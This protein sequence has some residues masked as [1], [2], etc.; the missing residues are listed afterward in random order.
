MNRLDATIYNESL[1]ENRLQHG[2]IVLTAGGAPSFAGK[3][4]SLE[5]GFLMMSRCHEG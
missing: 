3:K 1:I 2:I 5:E 4:P